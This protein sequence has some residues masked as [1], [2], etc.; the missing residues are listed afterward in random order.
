MFDK[1]LKMIY[2]KEKL[3]VEG[4][5]IDISDDM[6]RCSRC[7]KMKPEGSPIVYVPI[8]YM[9]CD[10]IWVLKNLLQQNKSEHLVSYCIKCARKY[11]AE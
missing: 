1:I 4:L 9:S 3:L 7:L 10:G 2:L 8:K 11:C 5:K 6:F